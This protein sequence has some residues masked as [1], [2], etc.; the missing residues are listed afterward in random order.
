[1]KPIWVPA[2]PVTATVSIAASPFSALKSMTRSELAESRAIPAAERRLQIPNFVEIFRWEAIQPLLP[3]KLPTPGEPFAWAGRLCRSHYQWLIPDDIHS[4]AEVLRLDEFDL[5]LRLFDFT[6]WRPYFAS[7]FRSQFGPPSFDP[8]SLGLGIF[9]AHYQKWD[10]E[11][12]THELRSQ[13]RGQDYC[14]RLGF[15]SADLPVPSTFRMAFA[16]TPL[17]W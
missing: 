17:D 3:I 12:L 5:L 16:Q 9:L 13:A 15:E 10:W 14:H 8:L 1:M 4:S 11:R 6:P 7:R 2:T